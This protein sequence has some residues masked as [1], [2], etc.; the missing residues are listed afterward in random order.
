MVEENYRWQ[1]FQKIPI[2]TTNPSL[3]FSIRHLT[4]MRNERYLFWHFP[5][6][7]GICTQN[8]PMTD[9]ISGRTNENNLKT[10]ET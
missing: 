9:P 2:N 1:K 5:N 4:Q 7:A 3:H 6:P 10:Y 8:D